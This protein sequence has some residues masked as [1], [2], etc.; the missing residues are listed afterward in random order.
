MPLQQGIDAFPLTV[1]AYANHRARR[2]KRLFPYTQ[3][4]LQ[5]FSPFVRKAETR[6]ETDTLNII[7]R[8]F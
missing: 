8:V 3:I 5:H 1:C 6:N 4:Q 7:F 2:R